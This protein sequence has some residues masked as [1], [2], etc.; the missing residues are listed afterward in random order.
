MAFFS[1]FLTLLFHSKV[2]SSQRPQGLDAYTT[3]ALSW[4][5]FVNSSTKWIF[6]RLFYL[7]FISPGYLLCSRH[8]FNCPQE[9]DLIWE[10]MLV[11]TIVD[12]H[13]LHLCCEKK[14]KKQHY[15]ILQLIRWRAIRNEEISCIMSSTRLPTKSNIIE[16]AVEESF[17]PIHNTVM[18][19]GTQ[20][21][22][23][24]LVIQIPRRNY[25]SK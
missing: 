21:E 19:A 25:S 6:R 3:C 11:D 20:E 4:W 12:S 16:H 24:I 17:W 10:S 18:I 14:K 2:L 9:C 13:L 1:V 15:Y 22:Q 5:P 7:D 23:R 8:K